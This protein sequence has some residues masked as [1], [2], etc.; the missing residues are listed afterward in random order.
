MSLQ[1]AVSVPKASNKLPS[2]T[3]EDK[4]ESLDGKQQQPVE[5]YLKSSLRKP[6]SESGAMNEVQKKSTMDGLFREKSC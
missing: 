2:E 6:S 1:K 5:E 3:I 4:E